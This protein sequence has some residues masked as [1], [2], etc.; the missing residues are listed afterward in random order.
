M[1]NIFKNKIAN[2]SMKGLNYG[3][4]ALFYDMI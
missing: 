3:N 4:L 2:D 1:H